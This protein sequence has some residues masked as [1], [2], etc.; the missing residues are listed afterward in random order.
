MEKLRFSMR[1][2]NLHNTFPQISPSKDNK[3]KTSI[4]RGTL[5]SQKKQESNLSTNL[6]KIAP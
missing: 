4:Q 2:Q 3:E 5:S 6:K 1:K